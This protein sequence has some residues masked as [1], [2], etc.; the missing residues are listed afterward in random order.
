MSN[1]PVAITT[2]T[3]Q[4]SKFKLH[5]CRKVAS[6][7]CWRRL[8]QK[9]AREEVRVSCDERRVAVRLPPE[10]R[11][12]LVA[13]IARVAQPTGAHEVSPRTVDAVAQRIAPEEQ[14]V[15][16]DD[17]AAREPQHD[18]RV[19]VAEV[20]G[21]EQARVAEIVTG[22]KERIERAELAVRRVAVSARDVG[23]ETQA[24][25]QRRAPE[26][27]AGV[28]VDSVSAYVARAEPA[29]LL[30]NFC[31]V[32]PPGSHARESG[33]KGLPLLAR[34]ALIEVRFPGQRERRFRRNGSPQSL[35][36]RRSTC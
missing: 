18:L 28:R 32:A 4:K 31:V 27:V 11:R 22:W 14:A 10:R 9:P 12:G 13:D 8:A 5:V 30:S 1:V 24:R 25:T 20:R 6:R 19:D 29:E 2:P 33:S 21:A 7:S 34:G 17:D 26:R 35:V 23:F 36:T 3:N 15:G 16:G